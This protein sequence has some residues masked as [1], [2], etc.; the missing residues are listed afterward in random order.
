MIVTDATRDEL[1]SLGKQ[2]LETTDDFEQ[3][4]LYK[5]FNSH[6]SHPD[7]ANLFFYPEN[8]NARRD[9]LSD[10]NPT[11]EEIVD[12]GINHKPLEL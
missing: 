6:F 1:I 11:V 12:I 7:V 3:G 2:L 5:V 4:V 8:Y 9:N 10:Y